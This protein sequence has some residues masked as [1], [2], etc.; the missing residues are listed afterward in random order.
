[1]NDYDDENFLD[2]SDELLCESCK[3]CFKLP[4]DRYFCCKRWD[5]CYGYCQISEE[6]DECSDYEKGADNEDAPT[7]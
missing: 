3:H 6:R 4:S 1:M 2:E 5:E 7:T